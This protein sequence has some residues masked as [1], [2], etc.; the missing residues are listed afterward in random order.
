MLLKLFY[1]LAADKN[2]FITLKDLRC[3]PKWQVWKFFQVSS[4]WHACAVKSADSWWPCE[5]VISIMSCTQHSCSSP[6]ESCLWPLLWGQSIIIIASL[7]QFMLLTFHVVCYAA[8]YL[9]FSFVHVHHYTSFS[10]WSSYVISKHCD[11]YLISAPP[12]LEWF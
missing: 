8:S 4:V 3:S 10:F 5:C 2:E 12:L 7:P 9:L 11:S 1:C 6:I